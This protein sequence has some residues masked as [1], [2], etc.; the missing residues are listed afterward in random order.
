MGEKGE[1]R[2]RG[3]IWSSNLARPQNRPIKIAAAAA[4]AAA[5]ASAQDRG[6][7]P[8]RATVARGEIL[9]QHQL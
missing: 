9:G 1:G 5:A 3:I 8:A 4:A 2:S 6:Q 7:L